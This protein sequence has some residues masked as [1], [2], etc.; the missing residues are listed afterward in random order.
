M[1][2]PYLYGDDRPIGPGL[3][4]RG[5][6][7]EGSLPDLVPVPGDPLEDPGVLRDVRFVMKAGRVYKRPGD[8]GDER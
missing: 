5:R 7:A 8:E 3:E 2:A 1:Y 4:D 6:I